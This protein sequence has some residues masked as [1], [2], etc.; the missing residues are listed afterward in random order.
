V[1]SRLF[2]VI[3]APRDAFH[4]DG[5]VPAW[6][7]QLRLEP[8]SY[9]KRFCYA[10]FPYF[11]WDVRTVLRGS[12]RAIVMKLKHRRVVFGFAFL[13][14]LLALMLWFVSAASNRCTLFQNLGNVYL[15]KGTLAAP[16]T[17]L[18]TAEQWFS[19][20][21]RSECQTAPATFG[22]GQ[23]Y[24]GLGQPFAAISAFQDGAARSD[25]RH[26]LMGRI[27]EA[28]GRPQDAWREYRRLPR[29]AA[30][31]FY[32]LGDSAEKQGDY[33]GAIHYFSVATTINPAYPKA[34]YAA[35]FLYWRRLGETDKAVELARQA[36]AVDPKPSVERD[37]YQGLLC[38][39]QQETS[40]A[41]AALVSATQE[42]SSLD[43]GS[44]PRYLAYEMLSR[45]LYERAL[46]VQRRY[47]SG[48]LAVAGQGLQGPDNAFGGGYGLARAR[49]RGDPEA[50][51][52]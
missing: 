47:D 21:L 51:A 35:A 28:M 25:L 38:Y 45:V 34:L 42:T 29:D 32:R 24:A 6:I 31:Y 44:S 8:S 33:Q 11:T 48:Q 9:R 17:Q 27:Y 26:F 46:L 50:E 40:C 13:V 18:G 12:L 19:I 39:Y 30:A 16:R 1:H 2:A 3:A 4:N 5:C 49:G 23:A 41:L 20:S 14:P 43:A 52:R 36:L 10:S 22:L 37:F 15:A 7:P